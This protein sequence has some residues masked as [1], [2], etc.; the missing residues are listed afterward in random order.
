MESI[1]SE[2]EVKPI[3]AIGK[4]FDPNLHEV[5]SIIEDPK[6]A[7]DTII[8]EIAKGYI[9][10]GKVLKYSKVCVSKKTIKK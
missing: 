10:R 7:E 8:E 3:D 5:I 6:L 2:Y 9:I 4:I 1:L